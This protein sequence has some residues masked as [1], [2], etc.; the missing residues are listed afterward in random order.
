MRPVTLADGRLRFHV[1]RAWD[2]ERSTGGGFEAR[3]S[4][5]R[6]LRVELKTLPRRGPGVALADALRESP[7]GRQGVVEV[8]AGDRVLLKHVRSEPGEDGHD[9]T[10]CW[11]LATPQ[12][13]GGA[14][15]AE[16][17]FRVC[18]RAIDAITEDDVRLLEREIREATFSDPP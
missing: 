15:V 1:P 10:Y 5:S 3:A 11:E 17:A 14:L 6:R 12:P 9:V 16:F 7:A 2:E 4:S 18:A 8:L 13:P